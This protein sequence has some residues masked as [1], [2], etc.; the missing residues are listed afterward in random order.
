MVRLIARITSVLTA[1]CLAVAV[2]ACGEKEAKGPVVLAPA[3][4]QEVMSDLADAWEDQGRVRPVLSIAGTPALARQIEAGAPADLVITADEEWMNWLEE[5]GLID[6]ENRQAIAANSLVFAGHANDIECEMRSCS[7]STN[8]NLIAIA[9]PETVPAGRY[10]KQA[11]VFA[12]SWENLQDRLVIVENV[13]AAL[14]LVEGEQV[15]SAIVY[16]SDILVTEEV[17]GIELELPVAVGI[18]YPA[19]LLTDASHSD[20]DAYLDFLSSDVAMATFCARGFAM[21]EGRDPC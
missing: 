5:R 19:A 18:T 3:S 7:P 2:A 1:F 21:P 8:K 6:R 16:A 11:L 9:D 10:A 12:G 20:A 13:R 4:M 17:S 14:A 15:Q